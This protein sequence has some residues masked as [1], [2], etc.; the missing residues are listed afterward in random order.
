MY[1]FDIFADVLYDEIPLAVSTLQR[2]INNKVILIEGEI[3]WEANS[4]L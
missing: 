2:K 3:Y 4:T 1:P